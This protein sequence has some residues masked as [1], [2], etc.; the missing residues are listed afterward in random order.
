MELREYVRIVWQ[1]RHLVLP[2]VVVTFIASSIFNL[3]LPPVYKSETT[4]HL[5]AIIPAP[6]PEATRF[7]S[8]EYFRT[9]HTEYIADD[10][11]IIV[12]SQDFAE[13]IAARIQARYGEVVTPKRI[14]EGIATTK[15]VHRT[16]KITLATGSETLTRQIGEAM[17]ETLRVDGAR[18]FTLDDRRLV[19]VNVI[20]PPRD[21]TSPS[22]VRRLLD[23]LLNSAVALVLGTG[24][25]FLLHYTDDHIR[26]AADAA[27]T[28]GWP[29]LGALPAAA[30][31]EQSASA[32]ALPAWA[33][34]L[35]RAGWKTPA[36]LLCL[37]GVILA[38]MM[39]GFRAMWPA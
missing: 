12:K 28:I 10:L 20:D 19:Q 21:P 32:G 8:E 3:I 37:T 13:K 25:A 1:R 36:A 23:V 14:V 24:L 7:Y 38:A 6:P 29:V 9:L 2:L 35:A 22:I 34:I 16:L 31:A 33:G 5:L 15:K 17:R 18:Y 4:V 27:R 11:S 39:M 26:N 30:V